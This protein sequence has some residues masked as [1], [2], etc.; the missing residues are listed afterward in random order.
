MPSD[1]SQKSKTKVEKRDGKLVASDPS[2]LQA[3]YAE[4]EAANFSSEQEAALKAIFR[5]L[6]AE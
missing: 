1:K 5:A 6:A 4:L 3:I 2:S